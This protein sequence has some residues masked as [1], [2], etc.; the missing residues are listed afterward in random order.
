MSTTRLRIFTSV[1]S[2]GDIMSWGGQEVK[3]MF[4]IVNTCDIDVI[5]LDSMCRINGGRKNGD[6]TRTESVGRELVRDSSSNRLSD[7]D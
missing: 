4:V 3:P 7:A 2:P 6:R 5:S 1:K